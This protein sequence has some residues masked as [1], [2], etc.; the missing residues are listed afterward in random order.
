MKQA[1]GQY[2]GELKAAMA[3]ESGQVLE[4]ASLLCGG[5]QKEADAKA[6]L[7]AICEETPQEL[8]T[9]GDSAASLRSQANGRA[10]GFIQQYTRVCVP[11]CWSE[12]ELTSLLGKQSD[13]NGG[14]FVALFDAKCDQ[15]ARTHDTSNFHRAFPPLESERLKELCSVV[16]SI[17]KES[18]DFLIILEGKVPENREKVRKVI[19]Q[20]SNWR[21]RE[22]YLMY[23]QKQVDNFLQ[24]GGLK[25]KA[26]IF[27]SF[28]TAVYTELAYVC[29]GED[30]HLPSSPL[31]G[32]MSL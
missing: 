6:E 10:D 30:A 15:D 20:M 28:A 14:R 16:G 24:A 22:V 9:E 31:C 11:E 4:V 18:Q 23:D 8:E 29:V 12:A 13:R 27:R 2:W 19:N 7:A 25:K 32:G 21:C 17:M 5:D 26:H 3:R 1:Y